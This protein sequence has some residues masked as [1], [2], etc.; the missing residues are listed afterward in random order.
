[1]LP[2]Y[3]KLKALETKD[4]GKMCHYFN[5]SKPNICELAL[6]N[7]F[8]WQ[9]F[10]H[11]KL[12]I[13]NQNL[14]ILITPPNEPPFFLEP[15]GKNKIPETIDTCLKDSG[16]MAR[17]S[18]EFIFRLDLKNYRIVC[19]RNHFDYVYETKIL[20]ELK[21]KKFDGKRNHIKNF[22]RRHPDYEF[23]PLN[24]RS[25]NEA[26]ELFKAW[27]AIRRDSR[28]FPR[29]A[30]TSQKSAIERSFAHFE[31]LNMSGGTIYVD[32]KMKGFVLGSPLN[33]ETIS[34]HFL[35]AHPSLRG[36][37]QTLLW[38]ACKKTF[39]SFKYINLEQDLGIPGL[40]KAKS[41][42]QPLKLEKKFEITAIL[43][44]PAKT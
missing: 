16:R 8:I 9:D 22:K 7:L 20:A 21:G 36:I 26:L 3:P 11:P 29:L 12:T 34:V 10:D 41:S 2:E 30:H 13:I 14:C 17:L 25:K 19:S 37:F 39:D 44:Q 18:E 5:K 28:F 4:L 33:H 6:A 42:Y 43:N 15:I 31:E 27:F 23:K 40:R 32:K 24:A 1:M 38:E 35:Y